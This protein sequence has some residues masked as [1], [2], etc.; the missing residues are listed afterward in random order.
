M[1][2]NKVILI[3][4]LG[5]DPEIRQ[6]QDGNKVAN[7]R[8]A[9]SE[10][11]KDKNTGEKKEHTEWIS[12]DVFGPLAGVC[13]KYMTSGQKVY[14]EGKFKTRKWQD[15]SGNDRYST[16]VVVQGFGDKVEMLSGGKN[17]NANNHQPSPPESAPIDDEI[18]F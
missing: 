2:V 3:G 8:L 17:Q 1:S 16:S 12:V 4:N 9:C 11:W 13:E 18:P 7:L 14:V 6:F 15:Q 10:T 5:A